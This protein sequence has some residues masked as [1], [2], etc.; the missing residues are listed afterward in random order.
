MK[1]TVGEGAGL[2]F[3]QWLTDNKMPATEDIVANR[4]DL[5]ALDPYRAWA[6]CSSAIDY[7]KVNSDAPHDGLV[8][9][10]ISMWGSY[11]E[12]VSPL[13]A[14]VVQ[15]GLTVTAQ[16]RGAWIQLFKRCEGLREK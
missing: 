6:A 11:P 1:G 14:R 9:N 2:A 13:A 5:G 8:N 16:G 15:S 7:L 3:A 10:M 4:V 12:V